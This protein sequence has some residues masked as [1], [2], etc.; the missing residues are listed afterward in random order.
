MNDIWIDNWPTQYK[1]NGRM[2]KL[3]SIE[4]N[5]ANNRIFQKWTSAQ[6]YLRM[7]EAFRA[8][9]KEGLEKKRRARAAAKRAAKAAAKAVAKAKPK[10][11]TAAKPQKK[12]KAGS[13]SS[14]K[15]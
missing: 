7:R 9:R 1:R 2:H 10:A 11:K 8:R 13:G 6:N 4:V 5:I 3:V 15:W 12:P 14:S